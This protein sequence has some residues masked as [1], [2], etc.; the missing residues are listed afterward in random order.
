MPWSRHSW[1]MVFSP[2]SACRRMWTICGS[3]NRL[4]R[5]ESAPLAG[6]I[7]PFPVVQFSGGRSELIALAGGMHDRATGQVLDV[8]QQCKQDW[9]RELLGLGGSFPEE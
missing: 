2:T 3:L 6:R 9:A 8:Y 5:I 1:P 7:L 4:L